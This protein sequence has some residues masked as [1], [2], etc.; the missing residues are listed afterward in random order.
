[1]DTASTQAIDRLVEDVRAELVA[2]AVQLG[3]AAR[4]AAGAEEQHPGPEN[5]EVYEAVAADLAERL[6]RARLEFSH[7]LDRARADAARR[8]EAARVE[9][10]ALVASARAEILG[11]AP[12]A[13]NAQLLTNDPTV[14]AAGVVSGV[15]G[16]PVT[17][18]AASAP[19]S[20]AAPPVGAPPGVRIAAAPS[21]R[22]APHPVAQLASTART[23]L[24]RFL[25]VDTILPIIAIVIVFVILLAWIG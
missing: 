6:G 15:V 9:G 19:T 1:V 22:P 13:G 16:E 12:V 11:V 5:P 14:S 25:Y 8:L 2:L 24:R 7:E 20:D 21:G 4:A 17:T 18:S 3:I 10:A 23:G